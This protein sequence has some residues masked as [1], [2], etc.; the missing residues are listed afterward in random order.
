MKLNLLFVLFLST[1]LASPLTSSQGADSTVVASIDS[2][3]YL[4]DPTTMIRLVTTME[5]SKIKPGTFAALP[6]TLW[7]SGLKD[8]RIEEMPDSANKIHGLMI[9]AGSNHWIINFMDSTGQHIKIPHEW[10]QYTRLPVFG[11]VDKDGPTDLEFGA[12]LAYCRKMGAVQLP[13]DTIG[14]VICTAWEVKQKKWTLKL[15]VSKDKNLPIRITYNQKFKSEL[16][17][18]YLEYTVGLKRDRNLFTPPAG[19]KFEE[20]N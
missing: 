12:E 14:G 4:A 1:S 15:S 9:V 17:V 7:R 18:N 19:I 13:D 8:A 16:A 10:K 20:Q 11:N 6:Q 2:G 5:S 3:N